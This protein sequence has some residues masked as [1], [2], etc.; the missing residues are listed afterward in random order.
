MRLPEHHRR[1]DGGE[2]GRILRASILMAAL[3]LAGGC[4]QNQMTTGTVLPD[5]S[6]EPS[7]LLNKDEQK[8]AI[9]DLTHVKNAEVISAEKLIE[10]G[11]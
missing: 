5:L 3:I 11:R 10:K 1:P 8:R 7:K 9:T 2:V 4:A 6:K